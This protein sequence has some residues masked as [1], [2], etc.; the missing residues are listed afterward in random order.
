MRP[1]LKQRRWCLWCECRLTG[2][3]QKNF[4]SPAHANAYYGVRRRKIDKERLAT[5]YVLKRMTLAAVAK[6]LGCCSASVHRALKRF[7]VARRKYTDMATCKIAGCGRPTLKRFNS[8]NRRWAGTRCQWH[9]RL[10]RAEYCR[11]RRQSRKGRN[12]AEAVV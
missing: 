2:T 11:T 1:P 6:E 3:Q 12:E 8:T 5:L 7:G 9:D 4:C 10:Y